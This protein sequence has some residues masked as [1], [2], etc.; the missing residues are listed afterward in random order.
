MEDWR[1]KECPYVESGGLRAYAGAPLRLQNESGDCVSLGSLCVAS[2]TAQDP[3]TK[4]QQQMLVRLADWVVSDIIQCARAR[5][6]RE[7]RNM[8]E[9]IST[10]QIEVEKVVSDEPILR[11]LRVI[12]R[13][14]TITLQSSKSGLIEIEGGAPVSSTEFEDGLWEDTDYIDD[15]IANANHLAFPFNR[16]LRV[17]QAPCDIMSGPSLLVVASKDFRLVFD[18]VDAWFI[19]TCASMLSQIWHKR[20]LTEVMKAKEKFLRGVSHQLRT[21]I[22]GILGS[23]ELLAEEMMARKQREV[24]HVIESSEVLPLPT[25]VESAN[26]LDT[27]K[28]ASRDLIS[29]VNSMITLNRWA[30]IAMTDRNYTFHTFEELETDLA[31]ELR[32]QTLGDTRYKP[33]VFFRHQ[34]P[35]QCG[36]FKVDLGL[37]RHSVFPLLMNAIQNTPQGVV[38]VTASIQ[39]DRHELIVDVEDTGC[40][41]PLDHQKRIFEPYEKVEM[42]SVGAGLGLTLASK[43]ATLLHGSV[44]LVS[45]DIGSGSHFR[46]IFQEV[47]CVGS[48]SSTERLVGKL[49]HMPPKFHN[50]MPSSA[51]FSLC[52]SLSRFLSSHGFES[53]DTIQGSFAIVD[54]L[55]DLHQRRAVFS[56][57][58]Q[59]H[60]AVC[61]VPTSA[62]EEFC[63]Q[64]PDDTYS[65]VIYS[66]GPFLTSTI[67]SVLEEADTRIAQIATSGARLVDANGVSLD[68]LKIDAGSVPAKTAQSSIEC[69]GQIPADI[70]AEP[71]LSV[72]PKDELMPNTHAGATSA[73]TLPTVH[74]S[75]KPV[76][77][78]VDDNAI[79]LQILQMY[80]TKRGLPYHCATDG[81]QAVEIFLRQQSLA[82]EDKGMP[83]QLI[84]MDLQMPVCDGFEATQQIRQLEKDNKWT[85]SVLFIVTGQDAQTDRTTAE[86]VGADEYF[87]KPVGIKVLDRGIK[88]YFPTYKAG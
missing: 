31:T 46:A 48:P 80:C 69:T 84:F 77:L 78:V 66:V 22:H 11:I 15:F 9:L 13:D 86:E 18:D 55:P 53:T 3:L 24:D 33:T 5:R 64:T 41:I 82:S 29:I 57:I 34:L 36:S 20:L 44:E 68:S 14:A 58:P 16:T 83:I 45:S 6:Q 21:P 12:Y 49:E 73:V 61:L 87:V 2:S 75:S 4:Q 85:E 56:R 35:V 8:S 17:M 72:P 1:F 88:R 79:N 81:K 32:K 47:E 40:G 65:N 39:P 37:L 60:V 27:I 43:F 74:K 19:Q 71:S 30:D 62:A 52:D 54:Y 26:Y 7:R 42:H 63:Q 67:I 59:D 10:A 25:Q 76:A 23:V 50:M 38:V 51:S 70:A 28:S